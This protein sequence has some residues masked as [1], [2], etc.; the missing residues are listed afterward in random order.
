MHHRSA[1]VRTFP[2]VLQAWMGTRS[3][4]AAAPLLG[5]APNT[6]RN[7][8]LGEC[9]PPVTKVPALAAAL[10]VPEAKLEQSIVR[11]P[12]HGGHDADAPDG[13]TVARVTP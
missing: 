10:G 12:R 5:V 7:W 11:K 3:A 2:R 6:L 8:L 9:V 1:N 13:S 4:E